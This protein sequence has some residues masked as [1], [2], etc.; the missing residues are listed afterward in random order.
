ML[1]I[2]IITVR[3]DE[4]HLETPNY[5]IEIVDVSE[6]FEGSISDYVACLKLQQQHLP[7]D[8]RL[9]A[10]TFYQLGVAHSLLPSC[11]PAVDNFLLCVQVCIYQWNLNCT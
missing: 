9:I 2:L 8:S 11:K 5:L 4:R 1:K 7:A 6:L 10:E 3:N